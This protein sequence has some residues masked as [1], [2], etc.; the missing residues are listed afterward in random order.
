MH[1]YLCLFTISLVTKVFL[2]VVL[3]RLF[4]FGRQKKWLLVALSR[5]S[6]YIVTVVREFAGVDSIL[7]VLDG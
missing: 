7:V 4:S 3:G 5:W 6:S 2:V 1:C